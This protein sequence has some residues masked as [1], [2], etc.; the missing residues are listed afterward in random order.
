MNTVEILK[1]HNAWRRG[2]DTR[3]QDELGFSATELGL[4]IDD[5]VRA[6]QERDKLR[7][8]LEE[9]IR[10]W[11]LT[12]SELEKERGRVRELALA[13]SS[14]NRGNKHRLIID[15]DDEPVY[16]QREEWVKWT[17]ELANAVLS[18]TPTPEGGQ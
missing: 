11:A 16:W 18:A 7:A 14:V 13:M 6:I 5:A 1:T 4:A 9:C 12:T 15:A 17:L 2:D 10:A 8:E 3:T